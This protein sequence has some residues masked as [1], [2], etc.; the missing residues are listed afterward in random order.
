LADHIL[1]K[2]KVHF[3]SGYS[4]YR[5]PVRVNIDPLTFPVV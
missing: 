3:G 2:R 4:I 1:M 5:A